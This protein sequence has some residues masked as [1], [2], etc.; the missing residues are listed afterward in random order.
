[1]KG[2]TWSRAG[3]GGRL[4]VQEGFYFSD[5]KDLGNDF[6]LMV[7]SL[8]KEMVVRVRFLRGPEGL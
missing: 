1:M 8:Q 2:G 7:R 3:V 5:G 4:G 6:I